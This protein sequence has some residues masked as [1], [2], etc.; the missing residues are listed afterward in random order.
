MKKKILIIGKKSFIGS[1]LKNYLSKFFEVKSISYENIQNLN[2]FFFLS[3]SHIINTSIHKNYIHKKYNEKFDLDRKI[4]NKLYKNKIIYIFLNSRK[5]YEPK[6]NISE[7]SKIKPRNNYAK[8]KLITERYLKKKLKK[9]LVSLRIS[10]VI[11]R[12]VFKNNRNNHNLFLDNFIKYKMQN[13]KIIVNDDFKDFIT[14]DHFCLII[15]NLI[16]KN[17]HGTFNVSLGR[18]VY[19]SEI[20]KWLNKNY[21][22]NIYFKKKNTDSFTL[23]NKK[24]LKRIPIKINKK[25]LKNFCKKLKI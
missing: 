23:S 19:V 1:N 14:I 7:L 24:L 20:T 15:K 2:N 12:R 9:K 16:N 18:K 25:Q 13:K 10:N 11:G 5:I 22:N 6:L 3:F 8:N 4:V 17:I 21:F